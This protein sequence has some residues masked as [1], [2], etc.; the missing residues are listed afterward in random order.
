MF[1]ADG[2]GGLIA[3]GGGGPD[4]IRPTTLWRSSDG[5]AWERVKLPKAARRPNDG[6]GVFGL[7]DD[8]VLVSDQPGPIFTSPD[9]I[10]WR[11]LLRPPGMTHGA[12]WITSMGD[13][14]QAHGAI[15]ND[16]FG[17]WTWRLGERAGQPDIVRGTLSRPVPWQ[18]GYIAIRDMVR[19]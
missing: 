16:D 11:R 14:V 19:R 3:F 18:G 10:R 13:R 17:L 15:V 2:P 12:R 1:M 6:V 7:D 9:G 8:W 4:S 5:S